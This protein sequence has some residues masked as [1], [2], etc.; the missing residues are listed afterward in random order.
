MRIL[1]VVTLSIVLLLTST[2]S[3]ATEQ[4][5]ENV[6]I[7]TA[8][9]SSNWLRTI[10]GGEVRLF[11]PD[12]SVVRAAIANQPKLSSMELLSEAQGFLGNNHS[13][14]GIASIEDLELIDAL[15]LRSGKRFDFRQ[16]HAGYPVEDSDIFVTILA[17]GSVVGAGANYRNDIVV[18]TFISFDLS[19]ARSLL[20]SSPNT[21]NVRPL[22]ENPVIVQD[23]HQDWHL[24]WKLA[25]DFYSYPYFIYVSVTTGEIVLKRLAFVSLHDEE[26]PA[27]KKGK[28]IL[29]EDF[30][31]GFPKPGWK[32]YANKVNS[33]VD[34]HYWGTQSKIKKSGSGAL[35]CVG[36]PGDRCY[37][38]FQV[39]R[40][41]AYE[42][43]TAIV[44]ISSLGN[45]I[46]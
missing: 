38:V 27:K 13:A 17:D 9:S 44:K 30:D 1:K 8:G 21:G 29:S 2:F 3:F 12:V 5:R 40:N 35:W 24:C 43:I 19:R 32:V 42:G 25:A 14:L 34:K 10:E 31:G 45:V 41:G 7:V 28:I 26:E 16:K 18:D 37:R 46:K 22:S 39:M 15:P 4:Q 20:E 36:K 23:K 6:E 11:R 33:L